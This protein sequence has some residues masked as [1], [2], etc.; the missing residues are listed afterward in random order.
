MGFLG[1]FMG[2]LGLVDN[3]TIKKIVFLNFGSISNIFVYFPGV[4]KIILT[5]FQ[6]NMKLK[7]FGIIFNF[8]KQNL[9]FL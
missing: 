4:L 2:S 1:V 6:L 3:Q 5:F 8:F 7:L 9:E